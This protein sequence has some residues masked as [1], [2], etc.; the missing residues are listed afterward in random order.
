M[1]MRRIFAFFVSLVILANLGYAA[2]TKE[3]L[4]VAILDPQFPEN[5]DLSL[6]SMVR[7]LISNCFVN[8]G[9]TYSIVERSQLDKVMQE[10]KF[11]NTDAVDES[12]AT[13]LGR[14]AGADRVVISVI[15]NVGKRS[16]FSIKLINVETA[17]IE[18]Q[19]SKLVETDALL[20]IIEPITMAV[21]GKEY[22][23]PA[24]GVNQK[25]QEPAINIG[26][27][28]S[29]EGNAVKNQA[30]QDPFAEVIGQY[31]VLPYIECDLSAQSDKLNPEAL[32]PL[33]SESVINVAYD[34]K[35][36]TYEGIPFDA[37][38]KDLYDKN[39][40]YSMDYF[41]GINNWIMVGMLEFLNNANNKVQDIKLSSD[42]EKSPIRLIVKFKEISNGGNKVDIDCIFVD[43]RTK[44]VLSGLGMSAKL[45]KILPNQTEKFRAIMKEKSG[46][47]ETM[48]AL[49]HQTLVKAGGDF[50][51]KLNK[52]LKDAKKK[53]KK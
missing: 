42:N 39:C 48:I 15:S 29:Q 44:A 38:V 17:S 3:S 8:Y 50:G 37:F 45:F 46:G 14:L 22:A 27:A 24:K 9:D 11:S 23:P 49:I 30:A 4:R 40:I 2:E 36:V 19:Q 35:D 6:Q 13:E 26:E 32:I 52:A 5:Q 47:V 18:K 20:D 33:L 1:N 28:I 41:N 7:E 16:L 10:A 34:W 25:P 12:Q 21:L 51:E 43:T 31:D 53:A